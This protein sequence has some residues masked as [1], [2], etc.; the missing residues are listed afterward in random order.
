MQWVFSP[1]EDDCEIDIYPFEIFCVPWSWRYSLRR[2]RIPHRGPVNRRH[3]LD[4]TD[5][6]SLSIQLG[7]SFGFGSALLSLSI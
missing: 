7:F 5:L 1:L 6:D 2:G 4:L 3:V